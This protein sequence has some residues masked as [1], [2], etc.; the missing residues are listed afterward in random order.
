MKGETGL[1]SLK[2]EAKSQDTFSHTLIATTALSVEH[3]EPAQQI[4]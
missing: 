4:I 2:G 1:G 3:P